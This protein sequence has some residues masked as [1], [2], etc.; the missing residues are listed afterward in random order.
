MI[1]IHAHILPGLDDGPATMAD[2]LKMARIAVE[3]G[4]RTIICL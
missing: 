1:D 2:A 4:I 3:D